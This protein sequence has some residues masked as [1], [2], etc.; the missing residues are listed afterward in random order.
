MGIR[1]IALGLLLCLLSACSPLFVRREADT[2]RFSIL[3][4]KA[5]S[6]QFACSLDGYD[7]HAASPKWPFRWEAAVSAASEEFKYFFLVDDEVYIPPCQFKEND[8]FGSQICIYVP[9]M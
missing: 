8:D 5:E 7:K 4:P 3:R 2:V 1:L 6:V 9:S